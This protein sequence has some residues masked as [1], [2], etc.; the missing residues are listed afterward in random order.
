MSKYGNI[1]VHIGD[2]VFDSRKEA[3]RYIE[4]LWLLKANQ[5]TDLRRQ[6]SFELIPAIRENGRTVQ[7]ATHYIA[8]FVYQQDGQTVVED[9]KS[10]ATKT[11][12]Y[13]MKKKLMRWQ[14]GIDIQEV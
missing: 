4:L 6:V 8:D 9:V 7:R 13:Q 14:Y 3:D 2:E 10:P 5:I 11:P 12:L 1:R